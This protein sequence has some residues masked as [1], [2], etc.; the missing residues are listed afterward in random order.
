[1]TEMTT[2]ERFWEKVDIG[3]E[4]ECWEW[5]AGLSHGYRCFWTSR[6]GAQYAHRVAW[7]LTHGEMPAGG[8]CL[9]HCDNRACVNPN[10]LWL[11][12]KADNNHDCIQK[13]RKRTAKG[14]K[15][16]ASKLT[17]DQVL[18][19]KQLYRTTKISQ[20]KLGKLFG[21][22]HVNIGSI[23]RREIWKHV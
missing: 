21:V 22:S 23:I 6:Q 19:I 17:V 1:M 2:E 14:E 13:G 15:H 3:T 9:H 8:C 18:K 16:G 10:H 4:S 12:S 5:Q 7:N 20:R 11:G